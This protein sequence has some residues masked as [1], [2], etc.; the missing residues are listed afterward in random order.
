MKKFIMAAAMLLGLATAANAQNIS[1]K[2][3]ANLG[4]SNATVKIGDYKPSTDLKLGYRINLGMEMP[5]AGDLRSGQ[6]YFS[7]GLT[8]LSKGH[9]FDMGPLSVKAMPHYLQ[10]P[11]QLGARW[12][13][14][15]NMGVSL[16]FGPYLAV[17]LGGKYTI[18]GQAFGQKASTDIDYFG[19]NTNKRFDFGA[20][21]QAA[22][23][24]SRYYFQVGTDFGFLN[25]AQ[26]EDISLNGS[27]VMNI[28]D[29]KNYDFFLGVGVHF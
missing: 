26:K 15:D 3:D 5:F 16:Q 24:Y 13:F 29:N 20:T 1:F 21:I 25:T 9:K 6:F 10:I 14:A 23:E 7:P 22:F 19:D 8:F 2:A 18:E 4:F 28:A 12:Q 27:K 11:L 17:G